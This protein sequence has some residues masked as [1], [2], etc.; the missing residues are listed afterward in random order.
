M[1]CLLSVMLN[2]HLGRNDSITKTVITVLGGGEDKE[3]G[4]YTT[5]NGT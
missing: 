2:I 4:N 5:V 3:R 1:T